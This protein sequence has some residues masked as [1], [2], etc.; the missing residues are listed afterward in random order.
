MVD[1]EL[2]SKKRDISGH[3]KLNSSKSESN[4]VLV[5]NALSGNLCTLSNLSNARDTET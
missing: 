1:I 3:I 2:K 4:R 5:I